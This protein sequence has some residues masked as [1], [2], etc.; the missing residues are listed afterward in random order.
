[1][2]AGPVQAPAAQ[3]AEIVTGVTAVVPTALAWLWFGARP[4]P[5]RTAGL[6]LVVIGLTLVGSPGVGGGGHAW[7]GDALFIVAGV[8]F[9]LFTVGARHWSVDPL[10][11]TAAGWVLALP[12]VPIY[13]AVAGPRRVPGPAR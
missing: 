4:W 9:A 8:L 2:S 7:L 12:Y 5:G 3:A 1:M 10:P 13:A 11:A 6:V